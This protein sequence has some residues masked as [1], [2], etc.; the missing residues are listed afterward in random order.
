MVVALQFIPVHYRY[1]PV[2]RSRSVTDEDPS[3]GIALQDL[4]VRIMENLVSPRRL[5]PTDRVLRMRGSSADIPYDTR[6]CPILRLRA[7]LVLVQCVHVNP[8]TLCI[9]PWTVRRDVPIH[10]ASTK[11]WS[12]LDV[13]GLID[14]VVVATVVLTSHAAA[15]VGQRIKSSL[16][17]TATLSA[18]RLAHTQPG[19]HYVLPSCPSVSGP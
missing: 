18:L 6:R 14:D 10:T 19:K 15:I 8:A 9:L 12:E 2:L 3:P 7:C 1:A 4:T 13:S 16:A 11:R 17:L 5:R